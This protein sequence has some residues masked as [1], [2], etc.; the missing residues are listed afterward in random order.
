MRISAA[1]FFI[2][3]S[4]FCFGD[5]ASQAIYPF[6]DK[7]INQE[8][9]LVWNKWDTENFVVLTLDKSQGLELKDLMEPVKNSVCDSWFLDVPSLPV[10]CKIMCVSDRELL[11][12]LF[13]IDAPHVEVR[14]DAEG[15]VSLCAIWM[16]T[17][18]LDLLPFLVCS[19]CVADDICL[20]KQSPLVQ[21]GVSFLSKPLDCMRREIVVPGKINSKYLLSMTREKWISLSP[22]ERQVFDAQSAI[23]CLLLRKEF[24]S[25]LFAQFAASANQDE[26]SLR[27]VYGFK[28]LE[29]LD[30]I[31]KRYSENLIKDINRGIVPDNY[32][33]VGL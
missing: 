9:G 23:F 22:K 1:V 21:R 33:A 20:N 26:S 2:I 27:L 25:D 14:R 32:L 31:L 5:E 4:S 29:Q 15:K 18:D 3:F 8:D 11:A 30:S 12:K 6:T 28:D 10:R 16:T 13:N 17:E 19:L 7:N 24:G